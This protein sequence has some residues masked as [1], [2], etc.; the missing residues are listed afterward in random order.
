M[1]FVAGNP[2][3]GMQVSTAPLE[4]TADHPLV[5]KMEPFLRAPGFPMPAFSPDGRW[6]AYSS[7]CEIWDSAGNICAAVPLVREERSQSQ[8]VAVGFPYGRPT[9]IS[10]FFIAAGRGIMV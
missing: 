6:L 5:G 10:F 4:G 2:F 9:R 7:G 1:A 3:T 8:T